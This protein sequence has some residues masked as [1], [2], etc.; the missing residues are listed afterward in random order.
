MSATSGGGGKSSRLFWCAVYLISRPRFL[1]FTLNHHTGGIVPDIPDRGVLIASRGPHTLFKSP[2]TPSSERSIWIHPKGKYFTIS[3]HSSG[4]RQC[5]A[6]RI[7]SMAC[8][9]GMSSLARKT[10]GIAWPAATRA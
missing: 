7:S 5:T 6:R 4:V 9:V 3:L 1:H 8:P 2:K 10:P